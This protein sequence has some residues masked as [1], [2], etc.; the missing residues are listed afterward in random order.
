MTS[1]GFSMSSQCLWSF[2]GGE[3]PCICACH[4]GLPIL[5]FALL[6]CP[7]LFFLQSFFLLCVFILI[8]KSVSHKRIFNSENT[9]DPQCQEFVIYHPG[10]ATLPF[11]AL[12]LLSLPRLSE[13]SIKP[14]LLMTKKPIFQMTRKAHQQIWLKEITVNAFQLLLSGVWDRSFQHPK[15]TCLPLGLPIAFHCEEKKF[16]T[17]LPE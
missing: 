15:G 13:L 6:D 9:E 2:A 5:L 17:A 16:C 11:Q 1:F 7:G 3:C 10:K 4:P 14:E 8:F 12:S